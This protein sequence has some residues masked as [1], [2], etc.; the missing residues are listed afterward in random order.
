ML[1]LIGVLA[2]ATSNTLSPRLDWR[3]F[4]HGLVETLVGTR[5]PIA[6]TSSISFGG[7]VLLARDVERI[8]DTYG[9]AYPYHSL[10]H[11]W[12]AFD[13]VIINFESTVPV[14]H[15]PTPDL[16]TN[17]SSP[18][19]VLPALKEAGVTH[20]GLANNHSFDKNVEGYIATVQ[21]IAASDIV[22][23]GHPEIVDVFSI[24]MVPWGE[25]TA[26]VI[27]VQAF[28]VDLDE[29]ALLTALKQAEE[30]SD[31]QIAYVHWGQ[32]YTPIH[33]QPQSALASF[34]IDNGIDLVIG[35]HPHVVQDI[36]VYKD[37]LIIYSLGN[38]IFDQYFSP[39][40]QV[41]LLVNLT[42]SETYEPEIV[43]V[44]VTSVGSRAQPRL[45]PERERQLWLTNLAK[46]SDPLLQS[47]V[48]AGTIS[49][50]KDLAISPRLP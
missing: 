1:M 30:E 13:T 31:V 47:M 36:Q 14:E 3:P 15:V 4:E 40:T 46:R 7:D 12:S 39:E 24:V 38:L 26:A 27:G 6:A 20:A 25:E 29:V 19:T 9:P 32:E 5:V 11:V 21:N 16:T 37:K 35:H 50:T 45:L 28:N 8:I 23:F 2:V 18:Q 41:G 17:F 10:R 34:L 22:P 48:E 49:I 43:L 42:F 33:N 44:P